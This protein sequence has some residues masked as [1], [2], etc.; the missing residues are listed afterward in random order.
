MSSSTTRI[1]VVRAEAVTVTEDALAVE[2]SDGMLDL[3]AAGVVPAPRACKARG[4]LELA[5]GGSRRRHSLASTRRG[6]QRREPSGRPRAKHPGKAS[7]RSRSGCLSAHH[8][9]DEVDEEAYEHHTW[10]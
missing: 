6:Y 5:I 3:R 2:L 1:P 4:T 10:R 9:D 7:G 8:R